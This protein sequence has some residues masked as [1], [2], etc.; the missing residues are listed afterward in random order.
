LYL[1]PLR[2]LAAEVYDTLTAEG[3]F[4]SLFTGQER[5]EVAFSTHTAATVEMANVTNEYDVVVM[6]EIQMIADS[7]RGAAWTRALLGLRCKEIHVCGGNEAKEIVQKIAQSCGDSFE[8]HS[9]E[10]FSPLQ[11]MDYSLAR[12]PK[13]RGCYHRVSIMISL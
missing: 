2:L 1:A 10:R 12:K 8:V 5:R 3:I 11:V 4:T 9:Y 6:D 7:T 13:E